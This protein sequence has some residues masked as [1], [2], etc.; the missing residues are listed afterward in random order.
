MRIYTPNLN[1]LTRSAKRLLQIQMH[2]VDGD[3]KKI[4]SKFGQLDQ[5]KAENV[6]AVV[7]GYLHRADIAASHRDQP[8]SLFDEELENTAELEARHEAQAQRVHKICPAITLNEAHSAIKAWRPSAS[9]ALFDPINPRPDRYVYRAHVTHFVLMSPLGQWYINDHGALMQREGRLQLEQVGVWGYRSGEFRLA[10]L[11]DPYDGSCHIEVFTVNVK[12]PHSFVPDM[13]GFLHRAWTRLGVPDTLEFKT[14]SR[15]QLMDTEGV[16]WHLP[17]RLDVQVERGKWNIKH[18]NNDPQVAPALEAFDLALREAD[19]IYTYLEEEP[20][21]VDWVWH[22][23]N[24]VLLGAS[25]SEAFPRFWRQLGKASVL[26]DHAEGKQRR[27]ARE[28]ESGWLDAL[29]GAPDW[30]SDPYYGVYN[31]T[32]SPNWHPFGVGINT[33]PEDIFYGYRFKEPERGS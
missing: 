13:E 10:M 32:N 11:F 21:D 33:D 9:R 19:D 24:L 27:S 30:T 2:A 14:P 5:S 25:A 3:L 4:I 22:E 26:A 17:K 29:N 23:A 1:L 12:R 8:S 15:G 6:T 31:W 16:L 7:L 28:L 18:I 20:D